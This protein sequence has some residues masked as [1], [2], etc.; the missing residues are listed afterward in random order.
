MSENQEAALLWGLDLETC[1]TIEVDENAASGHRRWYHFSADHFATAPA[2]M[3]LGIPEPIGEAMTAAETRPRVLPYGGGVL[4]LFRA[5]NTKPGAAPDDMV[6]VRIWL[7]EDLAVSARVAHR[8]L[9]A[10]EEIR[11]DLS[12]NKQSI[13]VPQLL[14]LLISRITDRLADIVSQFEEDLDAMED[15]MEQHGEAVSPSRLAETRRQI[16][17]IRRYLSPQRE[18]LNA[19]VNLRLGLLSEVDINLRNQADRT[20][21]LVE[22]LDLA[23][24]RA[25][26]LQEEMRNRIAQQQ[27]QRMYVLSL[28]TAL[29]LP[30]SFLTGMF[31]MNVGG[32]P[33]M[34]TNSGFWILS[35]SMSVI[36][37]MTL[38]WMKTKHWF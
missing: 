35:A 8:R 29:F 1:Q 24:E 25:L 4:L 19:L 27:N 3:S 32:L 18:A 28:V 36:A 20:T 2:L 17:G 37:V 13:T 30:L 10:A 6:S 34:E 9:R 26:L 15:D 22:E 14:D 5:V 38:V 21:R 11:D 12:S 23:K 16:V 33:L 31:G 7:H